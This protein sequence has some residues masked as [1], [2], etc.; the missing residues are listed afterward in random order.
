MPALQGD[1]EAQAQFRQCTVTGTGCVYTGRSTQLAELDMQ[2][3][4]TSIWRPGGTGS[5]PAWTDVH[6]DGR[7]SNRERF[8]GPAGSGRY[9]PHKV[10]RLINFIASSVSRDP[11]S[12]H[13]HKRSTS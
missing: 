4:R 9:F 6:L 10:H 1:D 8:Y 7:S 13:A 11:R 5:G 3:T 2:R 12:W